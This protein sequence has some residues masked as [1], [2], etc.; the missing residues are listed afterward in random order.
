MDES[1]LVFLSF[2][3]RQTGVIR[4]RTVAMSCQSAGQRID[5][6][7]PDAIND[8]GFSGMLPPMISP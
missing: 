1:V 3:I 5:I 6:G 2:H 8:P 7:A 4:R